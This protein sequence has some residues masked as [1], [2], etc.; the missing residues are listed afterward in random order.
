MW[1]LFDPHVTPTERFNSPQYLSKHF[2]TRSDCNTTNNS[3]S[4]K[5]HLITFPLQSSIYVVCYPSLRGYRVQTTGNFFSTF[6]SEIFEIR[7]FITIFEISMRN[8]FELVKR[9]LLWFSGYGNRTLNFDTIVL[10]INF[11]C[12]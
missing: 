4:P 6:F 10:K 1:P 5:W 7:I 11:F 9:A 2:L 12:I 8:L 3:I